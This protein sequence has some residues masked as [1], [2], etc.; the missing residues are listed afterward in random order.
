L[1]TAAIAPIRPVRVSWISS[2][3]H[4]DAD[5]KG[6]APRERDN[7]HQSRLVCGYF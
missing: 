3:I 5:G 4:C 7:S 1:L 2:T 6:D